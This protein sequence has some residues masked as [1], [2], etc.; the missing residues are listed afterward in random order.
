AP[1]DLERLETTGPRLPMMKNVEWSL[2]AGLAQFAISGAGSLVYVPGAAP[3]LRN[4]VWVDRQGRE[5]P[6]PAPR[7]AYASPRLSPD[8]MRLAV[9]SFEG[10]PEYW[11]GARSDIW[12]YD[13]A[14]DVLARLTSDHRSDVAVWTPDGKR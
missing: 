4:F 5:L 2:D 9:D 6:M 10:R 12:I 7:R 13:M 1:F 3:R 11:L 8:G 14:R